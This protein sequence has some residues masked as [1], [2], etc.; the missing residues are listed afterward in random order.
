ML[1]AKSETFVRYVLALE[2]LLSEMPF[3]FSRAAQITGNN[4]VQVAAF[5]QNE[6]PIKI[7]TKYLNF[8]DVFSDK[9][10]LVLP[11]Q[12]N[13]NEYAIKLEGNK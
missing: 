13:V 11:E 6:A 4:L 8:S 3:Y 5:N 12:I 9:K 2:A 10:T 1:D 7:L